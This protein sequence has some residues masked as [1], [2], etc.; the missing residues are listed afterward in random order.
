MKNIISF[1]IFFLFLSSHYPFSFQSNAETVDVGTGGRDDFS[2]LNL[3]SSNFQKGKDALKRALKYQKKNKVINSDKYFEKA[4]NYFLLAHKETS[5]YVEILTYLG[6]TYHKI[7]DLIMSEIYYQ[8]A[9]AVDPKNYL[10]NQRLGELYFSTNRT[11]LAKERLK[12]LNSCN[13][14]EYLNLKNII[15]KN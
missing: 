12:V 7:G 4:L 2:Y 15:E 3:K 11:N 9:L 6:F 14:P 1:V 13:C 10:L 5:N 8:E